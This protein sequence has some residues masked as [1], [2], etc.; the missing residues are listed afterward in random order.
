MGKYQ[1]KIQIIF[2]THFKGNLR[3]NV[4][5]IFSRAGLQTLLELTKMM[6]NIWKSKESQVL[7]GKEIGYLNFMEKLQTNMI[8]VTV[9]QIK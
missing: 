1:K 6:K 2:K 5:V 8:L 4:E 3:K 9:K 7:Y